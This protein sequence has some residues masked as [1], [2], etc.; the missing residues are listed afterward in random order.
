MFGIDTLLERCREWISSCTPR[1]GEER[2]PV[3]DLDSASD[4]WA[5]T[6]EVARDAA[7]AHLVAELCVITLA[8]FFVS[9]KWHLIC[10]V[11]FS[12]LESFTLNF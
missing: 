5:A 9:S 3:V 11:D 10:R 12:L 7:E 4:L 8:V 1:P 2:G 6:K